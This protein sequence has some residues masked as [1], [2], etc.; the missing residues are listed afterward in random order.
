MD[1]IEYEYEDEEAISRHLKC[2]LCSKPF[3]CPVSVRCKNKQQ[4]FCRNCIEERINRNHSCPICDRNLNV[5]NLIPVTNEI[6]THMLDD[7]SIKCPDCGRT[8]L[9]RGSFADHKNNMCASSDISSTRIRV[10]NQF[11]D[12]LNDENQQLKAQINQQQ[13][14]IGTL[15]DKNQQLRIQLDQQYTETEKFESE[16]QRLTIELNQQ[17]TRVDTLEKKNQQLTTRIDEQ[18][19]EIEKFENENQQLKLQLDRQKRQIET[20]LSENEKL[21]A[22]IDQQQTQIDEQNTK[23]GTLESN[24]QQLTTQVNEL[25]DKITQQEHEME[26]FRNTIAQLEA[27]FN[28]NMGEFSNT[29]DPR[30]FSAAQFTSDNKQVNN[31]PY[32]RQVLYALPDNII[33]KAVNSLME[34]LF[35]IGRSMNDDKENDDDPNSQE[36]KHAQ[37]TNA[38]I[39]TFASFLHD[40]NE[41]RSPTNND[42]ELDNDQDL[43]RIG[44]AF[45]LLAT[46][47]SVDIRQ[48]NYTA[49][50]KVQNE[51]IINDNKQLDNNPNQQQGII[52][53]QKECQYLKNKVKCFEKTLNSVTEGKYI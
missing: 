13:S 31:D 23:I 10:P 33:N 26:R 12:D 32:Q 46:L 39:E 24:N 41:S 11:S 48:P 14:E 5:Q 1:G 27:R 6:V 37:Y 36:T 42:K 38:I 52:E 7:L 19:T 28:M 30:R 9:K 16:N 45:N 44:T 21:K 20:L 35:H 53:L 4:T 8:R 50:L 18:K 29:T 2:P 47:L 40:L 25:Q 22:R 34:R 49:K 17:Q 15:Q 43:Q 51:E 3:V